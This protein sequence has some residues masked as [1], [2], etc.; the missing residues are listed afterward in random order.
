MAERERGEGALP[1][2]VGQGTDTAGRSLVSVTHLRLIQKS[3]EA[4]TAWH[5]WL[6]IKLFDEAPHLR[7]QVAF[8]GGFG[9]GASLRPQQRDL[10][11]LRIVKSKAPLTG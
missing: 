9:R 2:G 1:C 6:V 3:F 7:L 8:Q 4:I 10:H 11:P 5:Y